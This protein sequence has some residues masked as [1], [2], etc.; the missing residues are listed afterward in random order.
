M[1]RVEVELPFI[2][3]FTMPKI[4]DNV[5]TQAKA[6]GLKPKTTNINNKR[7]DII[8]TDKDENDTLHITILE[9]SNLADIHIKITYESEKPNKQLVG[10]LLSLPTS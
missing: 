3:I 10:Y 1:K 9:V 7:M 4:L 8:L 6:I 2:G 5:M